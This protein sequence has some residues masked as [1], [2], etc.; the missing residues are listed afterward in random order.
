MTERDIEI[1]I[2]EHGEILAHR[3]LDFEAKFYKFIVDHYLRKF[4]CFLFAFNTSNHW[5]C[6][7]LPNTAKP[8]ADEEKDEKKKSWIQKSMLKFR[9][10]G[11]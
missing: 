11:A 4:H 3:D 2:N 9:R 5:N 10:E 6:L 7:R 1:L 8:Q